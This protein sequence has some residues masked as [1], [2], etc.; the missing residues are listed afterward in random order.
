MWK[1]VKK[2]LTLYLLT[3]TKYTYIQSLTTAF[4]RPRPPHCPGFAMTLIQSYFEF[5]LA[6]VQ[7]KAS[8]HLWTNLGVFL[9]CT[10]RELC[11]LLGIPETAGKPFGVQ[12]QKYFETF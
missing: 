1:R 3:G 8:G 6:S 9:S 11:Y 12:D 5:K 10:D 4:S 7:M 2:F